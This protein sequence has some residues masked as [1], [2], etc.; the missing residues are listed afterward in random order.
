[1]NSVVNN[2]LL[3][4]ISSPSGTGKTSVCKGLIS[5][6]KN[7][8]MSVSHTTRPPRDNEKNGIDYYFI[9]NEEF[10]LEIKKNTFLEYA[11]VFGNFYGSSKLMVNELLTNKFD[12]LFD[13]DW[14]GASQIAN[15][16]FTNVVTFFLTPPS[17]SVVLK[18]LQKRSLETGDN[19][20]SIEKRM[21]EFENEMEHIDEYDYV[22]ENDELDKCI[23]QIEFIIQNEKK[24]IST[25]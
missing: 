6:N 9:S 13:I 7:M 16:H 25:S 8:K 5:N 1:M 17:K 20:D 21:M 22:V 18:R 10:Y 4:V 23:K 3:I 12:V 15:S 2:Q 14:Q 19:S 24:K 11:K